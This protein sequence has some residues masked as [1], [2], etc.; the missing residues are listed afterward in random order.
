MDETTP[1]PL[2]SA[3]CEKPGMGEVV[4]S[5]PEL[6]PVFMEMGIQSDEEKAAVI[7]YIKELF[8]L[9]FKYLENNEL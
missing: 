2:G 4:H 6:E 5:H 8:L 9:G 3:L 7:K 1:M